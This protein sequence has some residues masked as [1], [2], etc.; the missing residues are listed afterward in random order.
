M[1]QVQR[2]IST[3]HALGGAVLHDH[4]TKHS[5]THFDLHAIS[6]ENSAPLNKISDPETWHCQNKVRQPDS[7]INIYQRS[8]NRI[9][10]IK[11]VRFNNGIDCIL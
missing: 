9:R 5:C 2:S 11:Y 7:Y 8:I 1:P 3:A 10:T 6:R 4:V